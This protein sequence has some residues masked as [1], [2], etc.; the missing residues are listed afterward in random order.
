MSPMRRGRGGCCWLLWGLKSRNGLKLLV[1]KLQNVMFSKT[2]TDCMHSNSAAWAPGAKVQSTR[3]FFTH[4]L[5]IIFF[6]GV[7][8]C[9]TCD[10]HLPKFV[11][12]YIW[13]ISAC[14]CQQKALRSSCV[15]S[16]KIKAPSIFINV[17]IVILLLFCKIKYKD[18][19][20]D[21]NN[22]PTTAVF[23]AFTITFTNSVQIGICN[24]SN[25]LK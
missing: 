13:E 24:I 16:A 22:Y 17:C 15:F 21:N 8:Q 11:M 7:W 25:V 5:L 12:R 23:N 3:K 18:N 10:K 14:C 9:D 6:K 20:N 1:N 4:H 2:R 19:N